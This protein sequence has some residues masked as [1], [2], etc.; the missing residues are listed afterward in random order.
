M[1]T[2]EVLGVQKNEHLLSGMQV[3]LSFEDVV[4]VPTRG[5]GSAQKMNIS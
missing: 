3:F 4:C 2:D 5:V 1:F